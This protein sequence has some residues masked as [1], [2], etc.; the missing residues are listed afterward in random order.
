M[1]FSKPLAPLW[2]VSA[3]LSLV[4]CTQN[5]PPPSASPLP[6]APTRQ[7]S[8]II[9]TDLGYDVDDVGALA[10]AHSLNDQNQVHLLAT[11]SVVGDPQSAPTIDVI[12]T[13]FGRPDLPLGAMQGSRWSDAQGYWF[14][15]KGDF[16][17]PLVR[18]YPSDVKDKTQVPG[19]VQVYRQALSAAADNSVTLVALGF[20][21]N[22]AN[23]LASPGDAHSP[24]DG[25]A[26]VE[27][28][29]ERLVYMGSSVSGESPDFNL[30]DGPY[31]EGG[32]SRWMLEHWPTNIV[33][34][35]T[36]LGDAIFTGHSLRAQSSANPV[37]EAY[38]LYPGVNE[39]GERQSWDLVAV[40]FAAQGNTFWRTITDE[41]IVI[42]EDGTTR[43]EQG[44]VTPARERLEQTASD[45]DVETTLESLLSRAPR[46]VAAT[47]R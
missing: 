47:S 45:E 11:V 17:N 18:G 37:A 26:L 21:L 44:A 33:F 22:L 1:P 13:Y 35:G 24:L 30:G 12:N 32:T 27:K 10:V 42:A 19:A 43:W 4:G 29:V 36:E 3:T 14:E 20:S 31:Q 23:L 8:L 46:Q 7:V 5:S 9:D 39:D 25:A 2:V 28:K 40:L 16:L 34:V 41:H 6:P 38:R 15:T